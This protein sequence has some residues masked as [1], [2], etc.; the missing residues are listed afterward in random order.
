M[1]D[2]ATRLL[3][4]ILAGIGA[5]SCAGTIADAVEWIVIYFRSLLKK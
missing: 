2:T 3:F 4:A 5:A 1:N